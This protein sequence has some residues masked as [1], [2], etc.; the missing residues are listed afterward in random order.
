ML[1]QARLKELLDYDPV[2]GIFRRKSVP[3]GCHCYAVGDVCGEKF[4]EGYVRLRLPQGRYQAHRL[5][6]LYM[7]GSW[8]VGQIDHINGKKDENRFSNL[9]DVSSAFNT[10]N[11][12]AARSNSKTGFLGVTPLRDK[13]RATIRVD[14]KQYSLGVYATPEL[15]FA[16]YVAAKRD[17]HGGCTI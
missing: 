8:P 6:W 14:G 15:A 1:T 10:Q 5:A 16:A 11:V 12:T 17:M 9:R 13:F 4:G 3:A 7:T 2:T